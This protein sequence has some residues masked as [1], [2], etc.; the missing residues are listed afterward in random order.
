[1]RGDF[2]FGVF[3]LLLLGVH[4]NMLAQQSPDDTIRLGAVTEH[5]VVYPMIFLPEFE[6]G[7]QFMNAEQRAKRLK[8]KNDVFVVY[9]YAI[10]AA[11]I[12]KDINDSLDKMDRRHDRKRYLKSLDRQLDNVFK[13]PLKNLSIDQGH[14]LIKLVNRQTGQN[15]YTIIKELKGGFSAV[16]WQSVGVFFNN[17]LN[18]DYDPDGRDHEIEA[19]VQE[20]EASYN[21]KYQLY[22]QELLLKKAAKL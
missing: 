9:P 14:V 1:M 5:G 19:V 21:Y 11:T 15:C 20:M 10:T 6:K 8:L 2:I 12:L 16:L 3:C 22:Q 7:A 17:N 4:T 13:E 18:K